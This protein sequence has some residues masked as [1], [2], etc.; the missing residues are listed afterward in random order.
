MTRVEKEQQV[1]ELAAELQ[2]AKAIVVTEYLGTP[3][4]ELEA[5]RKTLR[6]ANG[7]YKVVKNSLVKRALSDAGITVTD[8]SILDKPIAFA[9]TT[10]DE[11]ALSKALVDFNKKVETVVP[12]AGI[13]DHQFVGEAVIKRLAALPS[14]D[15]LLAS[16]VGGL[17]SLTGRMVRTINQP[18]AGLAIVL[19]AIK[20]QK[21]A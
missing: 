11:V 20:N 17:G 2:A 12:R 19:G 7:S 10:G 15:Q 9:S 1:Q 14:R 6:E 18:V 21:E 3:V 4:A 13:I 5:L 8:E 16:L